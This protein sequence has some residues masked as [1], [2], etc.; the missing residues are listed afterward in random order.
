MFS[1][2]IVWQP[3]LPGLHGA[4]LLLLTGD[5]PWFQLGI[6]QE[7]LAEATTQ[8]TTSLSLD[9]GWPMSADYLSLSSQVLPLQ[10]ENKHL[11]ETVQATQELLATS[12]HRAQMLEAR[13]EHLAETLAAREQH[14]QAKLLS[15]RQDNNQLSAHRQVL[16]YEHQKLSS[17][18]EQLASYLRS[19]ENSTVFRATRPLVK[20]KMQIDRLLGKD[21]ASVQPKAQEQQ[22]TPV[23]APP[24]PVDVIVPVYRGLADTKLCVESVLASN[25]QTAYRLIVINDASPEPEVTAWLRSKAQEDSRITLLENETNLGF[26][27]TVN[28]G[29]ALSSSNDVLLLNSDTEVANDWLDRIRQSAYSDARVGTVTP[30]SNNATICS[31]PSFCKDNE[32]PHGYDTAKLD[33]LCAATNAGVAVDVPDRKSV[34]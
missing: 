31:Y 12:V 17:E 27:G 2:E 6:P 13:A 18:F 16:I 10:T 25:C 11:K 28:R 19:I 30:F 34:V 22:A 26:V 8:G 4:L 5:D 1:R 14:L 21:P 20:A 7:L 24:H 23:Q 15:A 9:M 3:W 29:M 33:A 32:L